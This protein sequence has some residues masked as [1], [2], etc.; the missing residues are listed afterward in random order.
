MIDKKMIKVGNWYKSKAYDIPMELKSF[1][2]GHE[3]HLGLVTLKF[4]EYKWE[5]S[6]R[7]FK[8]MFVP[9]PVN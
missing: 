8:K 5:G 9:M 3:P 6:L 1:E 4:W 7:E 2:P